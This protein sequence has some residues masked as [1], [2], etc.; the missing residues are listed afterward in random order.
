MILQQRGICPLATS[1]T[2]RR[3][4]LSRGEGMSGKTVAGRCRNDRDRLGDVNRDGAGLERLKAHLLALSESLPELADRVRARAEALGHT[5]TLASSLSDAQQRGQRLAAF[6]AYLD[7]Y[8][9]IEGRTL[10]PLDVRALL[11]Q[12]VALTRSEIEP[13]ARLEARYLPAPLVRASSHQLGQVFVSLLINAAQALPAGSPDAHH[14]GVELDTGERGWARVAIAD[15]GSGI[16]AEVLP[17]IFEPLFST[18]RGAGMGI[19]LAIVREVIEEL[20]GRISVES[21]PG[22]GTLFIIELPPAS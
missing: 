13:K 6:A 18:K 3:I 15:T 22:R 11:E 12:A 20:G 9:R 16:S 1:G 8:S 14:V 19:G 7:H 17:R 5:G 4:L 10:G 21:E 2:A